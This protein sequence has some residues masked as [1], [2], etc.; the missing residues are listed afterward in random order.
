M[1][2]NQGLS[3]IIIETLRKAGYEA[4]YVGGCVRDYVIE[5]DPHDY[6]IAT[7]AT[8][9]EMIKVLRPVVKEIIPTGLKH[10]TISA[11]MEDGS[12]YEVTTFR[13]DGKYSD[14]RHPDEVTF[15]SSLIE[16]LSRRDFTINAMAMEWPSMKIIDPFG[17]YVDCLNK[18]IKCVGD[19]NKR[20]EEDP[21]RIL[22]GIR[23]M[24]TLDLWRFDIPTEVAMREQAH[25]LKNIS[26]ERI[27]A[28]VSKIM[29]S[30]PHILMDYYDVIISIIPEMKRLNGFRQNNPYHKYDVYNH[31]RLALQHLSWLSIK[32]VEFNKEVVA[33]ALLLH[34][35]GK[36]AS[37]SEEIIDGQVHGH[38]YGHENKS[39]EIAY[40]VLTR[41][42]FPSATI[43]NVV[44]LIES[45]NKTFTPNEK[46][47]RRLMNKHGI[48]QTRHLLYHNLCDTIGRGA[49]TIRYEESKAEAR[50]TIELFEDMMTRPQPFRIKDLAID[51]KDVMAFGIEQS[52]K[53]GT[54][55][56]ECLKAVMEEQIANERDALLEY[57]QRLCND[58]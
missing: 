45:H 23:L 41:L 35:T 27:S 10:G 22:R 15:T 43:S 24:V 40:E 29:Q 14:N 49:G 30:K 5:I 33:L 4:V 6:D 16:D 55:L 20:F 50:E 17:G 26:A 3:A 7:S 39:A 54:V 13:V 21:L 28:E 34:D 19:A 48:L 25:L 32:N 44:E 46:S 52:P 57:A 56:S 58:L 31:T 51:G 2:F 11:V 53:V 9:D 12:I 8:P 36:P 1:S 37:Y 18:L 38:F 42:R 47:I